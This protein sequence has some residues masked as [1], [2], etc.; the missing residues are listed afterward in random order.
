MAMEIKG[1][2]ASL[3]PDFFVVKHH[4]LHGDFIVVQN[5]TLFVDDSSVIINEEGK[6][7]AFSDLRAG[8]SVVGKA[9]PDENDHLLVCE[10][11]VVSR[12][13]EELD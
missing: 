7:L 5:A 13:S 12:L 6:S 1:K 8:Q 3:G 9:L 10:V 11:K 4:A 2:I